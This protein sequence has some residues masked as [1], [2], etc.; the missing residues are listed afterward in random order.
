MTPLATTPGTT[1]GTTAGGGGEGAMEPLPSSAPSAAPA[2]AGGRAL[3]GRNVAGFMV[4]PIPATAPEIISADEAWYGQEPYSQDALALDFQ[5]QIDEDDFGPQPTR[6]ALLPD[7][8]PLVPRLAQTVIEVV[9]GQRPA[10]QLIRHTAPSVYSVLA[11]QSMVAG[12]RRT[13]GAQRSPLV[14]RVRLC[15]P[16]DGVVEACAVVVSHGRVRALAMRLEGLD[17]RWVVT[18]L[19]IG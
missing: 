10:P 1:P 8:A 13:P 19:T 17:G 14:R 18:A 15:E 9:S 3:V 11:R 12:R 2:A 6:R 4:R 16:A 7:P 5:S